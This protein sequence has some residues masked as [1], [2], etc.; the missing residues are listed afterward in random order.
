ME[1]CATLSNLNDEQLVSLYAKGNNE[2]FDTLLAR[3]QD[4]VFQYIHFMVGGNADR[5]NDVFQDTFVKAIIAIREGR[6]QESGQFAAWLL[7]IA[8]NLVLDGERSKKASR[9]VSHEL[10]DEEGEVKG[11]LLNNAALCEPNAEMQ[12]VFQQSLDDVRMMVERL[13]EAQR[14]VVVLRFYQEMPFKDIARLTGVS[15]NTALGRMRYAM[16]NLR[17]M[18]QNR[19]LYLVG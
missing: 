11:N 8:R 1:K 4:R 10:V 5:A 17:R 19:N 12:M 7:R 18:A 14:E 9:L 6:Y 2:A 13:P 16:L 15:I 3:N